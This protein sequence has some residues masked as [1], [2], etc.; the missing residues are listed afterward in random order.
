MGVDKMEFAIRSGET[1]NS[2]V[3]IGKRGRVR[4]FGQGVRYEKNKFDMR[5]FGMDYKKNKIFI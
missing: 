4:F 2:S 3:T 5:V 1:S